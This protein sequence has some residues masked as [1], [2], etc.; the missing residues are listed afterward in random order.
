MIVVMDEGD[1]KV[2]MML[3]WGVDEMWV[4]DAGGKSRRVGR[5]GPCFNRWASGGRWRA[6][7]LALGLCGTLISHARVRKKE[8]Q[9]AARNDPPM[10]HGRKM[11][12]WVG[13]QCFGVA[14]RLA[15]GWGKWPLAGMGLVQDRGARV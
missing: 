8:K 13:F 10:Q 14:G 7:D 3:L 9:G 5:R 2:L 6:A 4:C 11:G 1:G 12:K 15:A